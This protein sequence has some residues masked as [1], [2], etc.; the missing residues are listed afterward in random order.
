MT[1]ALGWL[2]GASPGAGLGVQYVLAG[3]AYM[4]IFLFA[5]LFVPVVRNLEDLIPDHVADQQEA[6]LPPT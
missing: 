4:L 5:L 3:V 1:H 2:V 6:A